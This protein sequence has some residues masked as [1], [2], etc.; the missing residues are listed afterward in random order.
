MC[1]S[2]LLSAPD[3][4]RSHVTARLSGERGAFVIASSCEVGSADVPYNLAQALLLSGAAVGM[5]ASTSVTPGDVTD[6]PGG[7]PELDATTYG[8]T[9]GGIVVLEKLRAGL[10]G[11][12]A[13]A[14]SKVELGAGG[15][16]ETCAARMMINWFG[17]PTLRLK[18]PPNG[19]P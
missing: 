11:A 13:L 6:Y 7:V 12:Q 19:T 4:L 17:D 9:N 18:D 14:R 5:A 2:D 15:S 1:S 8:I 10:T 3:L 16:S